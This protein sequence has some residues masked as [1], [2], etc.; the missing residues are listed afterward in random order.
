MSFFTLCFCHT[1]V[2][3]KNCNMAGTNIYHYVKLLNCNIPDEEVDSGD[4]PRLEE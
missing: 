3:S 2:W 4:D 1:A